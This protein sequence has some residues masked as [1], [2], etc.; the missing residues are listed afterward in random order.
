MSYRQL[1]QLRQIRQEFSASKA[2]LDYLAVKW[3]EWQREHRSADLTMSHVRAAAEDVEATYTVRVFSS[4]EAML[5][6]FLPLGR[7]TTTGRR[8]VY[9]LINRTASRLRIPADIRDDVHR[10]REYR[11]QAVHRGGSPP[12]RVLFPQAL[13]T[14]N[15]FV[16]WLPNP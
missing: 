8:S 16:A 2:A 3:P 1:E 12:P 6:D 10:L 7:I 11:N 9:D 5:R 4:F 15:R 13:A 14:L